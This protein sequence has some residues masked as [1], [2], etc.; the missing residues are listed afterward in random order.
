MVYFYKT[1]VLRALAESKEKSHKPKRFV[2]RIPSKNI[3]NEKDDLAR[4]F[5]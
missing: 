5:F 3:D 4:Y 2:Q 1:R